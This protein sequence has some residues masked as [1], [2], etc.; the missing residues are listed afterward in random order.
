M[1]IQMR[2]CKLLD[3]HLQISIHIIHAPL[4]SKFLKMFLMLYK[5]FQSHIQEDGICLF[6]VFVFKMVV[7]MKPK[8]CK[9]TPI[10]GP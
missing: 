8:Y 7:L 2:P 6:I 4:A 9:T 3:A 1:N 5:N 10:Y